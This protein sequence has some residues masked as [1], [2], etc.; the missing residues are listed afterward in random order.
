MKTSSPS[1]IRLSL[2]TPS[3]CTHIHDQFEVYQEEL[4]V[5]VEAQL[6]GSRAVVAVIHQPSSEKCL[7]SHREEGVCIVM[8]ICVQITFIS[9][10]FSAA[11]CL[12]PWM[13]IV[14]PHFSLPLN[15]LS[16]SREQRNS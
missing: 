13:S 15:L 7:L 16:L 14:C 5:L 3:T 2:S 9:S 6:V 8:M 11:G 4:M 1:N 12:E 10:C